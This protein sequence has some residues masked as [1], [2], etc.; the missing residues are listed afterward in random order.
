MILA[1]GYQRGFF[2]APVECMGAAGSETAPAGHIHRV[3]WFSFNFIFF[4]DSIGF[5]YR[6]GSH[7]G[8]GIWVQRVVE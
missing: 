4:L 6:Y 5:G 8:F 3:R 7:Q 1:R 2:S